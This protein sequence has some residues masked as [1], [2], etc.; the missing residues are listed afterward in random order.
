[1]KIT[2]KLQDALDKLETKR[3][4][5]EDKNDAPTITQEWIDAMQEVIDVLI[6]Q[7]VKPDYKNR[8]SVDVAIRTHELHANKL[9]IL[10]P[11]LHWLTSTKEHK[12]KALS[13]AVTNM[14]EA[15]KVL[16][17]IYSFSPKGE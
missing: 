14:N 17:E 16:N 3:C 15:T 2:K 13:Y 12:S 5:I 1:M 4:V 8:V 10:I 6:Q 11:R 9:P 7:T